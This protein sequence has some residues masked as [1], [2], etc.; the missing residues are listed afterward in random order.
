MDERTDHRSRV[1]YIGRYN[2][3]HFPARVART[4]WVQFAAGVVMLTIAALVFWAICWL[5]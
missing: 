4:D 3:M 5:V 1:H 2:A